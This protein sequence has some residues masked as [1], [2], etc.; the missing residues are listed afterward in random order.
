MRKQKWL[1]ATLLLWLFTIPY[2]TFWWNTN[3]NIFETYQLIENTLKLKTATLTTNIPYN[4][5]KEAFQKSCPAEAI[6]DAKKDLPTLQDAWG[7]SVST[8]KNKVLKERF[9]TIN[10]NSM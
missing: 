2:I 5:I 8:N 7:T 4:T 10:F 1:L 3:S 6:V 9:E